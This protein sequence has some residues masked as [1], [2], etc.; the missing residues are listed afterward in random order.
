MPVIR[1]G[2]VTILDSALI[3]PHSVQRLLRLVK[4][5]G[6]PPLPTGA[7]TQDGPSLAATGQLYARAIGGPFSARPGGPPRLAKSG[8]R[9]T[10]LRPSGYARRTDRT[11]ARANDLRDSVSYSSD[12]LPLILGG[13]SFSGGGGSAT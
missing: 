4:S 7:A 3:E 12:K 9:R 1:P 8:R 11:A 10:A 5:D 13:R 2:L 6:T